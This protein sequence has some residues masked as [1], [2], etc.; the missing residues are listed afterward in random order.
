MKNKQLLVALDVDN[1]QQA[2]MLASKLCGIVGGFKVG[3]RL[4]V[5]ELEAE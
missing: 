2:M 3:K 1:R 4:F 5:S